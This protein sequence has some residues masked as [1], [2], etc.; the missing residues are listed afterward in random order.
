M[1]QGRAPHVLAP[2]G[3]G[4]GNPV[5]AAVVRRP[6]DWP[7]RPARPPNPDREL[8]CEKSRA[9]RPLEAFTDRGW[10]LS[11]PG[12]EGAAGSVED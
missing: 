3:A 2:G 9:R 8:A 12:F 7:N 11:T 5:A 6:G 10:T 4:E 1:E